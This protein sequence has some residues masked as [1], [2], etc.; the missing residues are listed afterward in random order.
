MSSAEA[1]IV[2]VLACLSLLFCPDIY[3]L[4][5]EATWYLGATSFPDLDA[6]GWGVR[7]AWVGLLAGGFYYSGGEGVYLPQSSGY[8]QGRHFWKLALVGD[9]WIV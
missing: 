8:L 9:K 6:Y 7:Y 3:V 4:L 1:C 5:N 2:Q